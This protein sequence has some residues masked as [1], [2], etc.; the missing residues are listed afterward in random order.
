MKGEGLEGKFQKLG[1]RR[2]FDFVL[3]LPLCYEDETM[4]GSL[5]SALPG[6]PL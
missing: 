6:V 3:H 2:G 5:D 1:L 4:L